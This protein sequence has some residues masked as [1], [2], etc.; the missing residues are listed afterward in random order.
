MAEV[1]TPDPAPPAGWL[2]RVYP[3]G[4]GPSRYLAADRIINRA[5]ALTRRRGEAEVFPTREA[6][7]MA[8]A[9]WRHT[10]W[11]KD[12]RVAVV[13]TWAKRGAGTEDA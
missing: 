12:N 9:R 4:Y 8:G 10:S 7:A 2:V 5:D 6:A 1:L 11:G 13:A 3:G